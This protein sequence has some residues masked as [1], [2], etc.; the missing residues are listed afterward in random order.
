[1]S[2][3]FNSCLINKIGDQPND[4]VINYPHLNNGKDFGI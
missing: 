2:E 3:S 4:D 1:M